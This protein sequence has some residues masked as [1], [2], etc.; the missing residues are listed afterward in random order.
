MHLVERRPRYLLAVLVLA[1]AAVTPRD[2]EAQ[3]SRRQ[4]VGDWP[5]HSTERQRPAVVDPGPYVG[6]APAPSDA[7]ILFDGGDL[8]AWSADRGG[9]A[10]WRI[11]GDAMEVVPGTGG[12]STRQSFGD[13]QLHV[14]FMSPDPSTVGEGQNRGNS[15]VFLMGRYEVQVLDSYRA[16]TYPDGQAGALYGQFPPLVNPARAPGEWNVYD[17]VFRA[18][19]FLAD[20]ALDEPARFTVFMN[21]VLI[22]DDQP[23]VGPTSHGRRAPYEAHAARLPIGLQDHEHAVRFRNIWV[24]EL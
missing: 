11:V 5:Q 19:R 15:G 9:D 10:G 16:D 14:E 24:R 1:L 8:S 17:I 20:G 3:R 23:L 21:G 22:H 18:P 6:P 7:I 4:T 13:V 2:A 12:I